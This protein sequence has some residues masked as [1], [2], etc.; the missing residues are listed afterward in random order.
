LTFPDEIT[1]LSGASCTAEGTAVCSV[2]QANNSII[3]TNGFDTGEPDPA[4]PLE[5]EVTN[6]RNSRST[7]ESSSFVFSTH[8]EENHVV[9]QLSSGAT[10][11]VSTASDITNIEA[12]LDSEQNTVE[13]NYEFQITP[14]APFKSNDYIEIVIPT[15]IDVNDANVNCLE[16]SANLDSV[17]CTYDIPT[18]T[19]TAT[20]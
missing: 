12:V 14:F 10:I 7:G 18:K 11:T 9:D 15:E 2:S 3:I 8:V 6:I 16:I 5:F 17:T 19:V 20:I 13:T 4:T 1:I